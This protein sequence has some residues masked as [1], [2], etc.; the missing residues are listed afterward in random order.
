MM[1]TVV[2]KRS[3]EKQLDT[4]PKEYRHKILSIIQNLRTNPFLGKRL[5][6]EISHLYSLRMWPY[7]IIY[8]VHKKSITITVV[9]IGHRK[10]V[11]QKL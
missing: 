3:A 8:S 11:Y 2:F 4:L 1:Y 7:R 6:G 9:A 5:Q 10:D